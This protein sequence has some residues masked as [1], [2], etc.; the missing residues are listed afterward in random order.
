MSISHSCPIFATSSGLRSTLG[1][2]RKL[3]P[4]NGML[5]L[6][7]SCSDSWY[8]EKL[9]KYNYST[10]SEKDGKGM[11]LRKKKSEQKMPHKLGRLDKLLTKS[12]ESQK[13]QGVLR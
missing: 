5:K 10:L 4:L 3:F 12:S 2:Q 9:R 6:A 11:H 1:F 13:V 7:P 8:M